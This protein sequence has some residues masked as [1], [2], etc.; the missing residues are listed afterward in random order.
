MEILKLI[1]QALT[2]PPSLWNRA[3]FVPQFLLKLTLTP[4]IDFVVSNLS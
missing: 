2:L 1:F 3:D 4:F